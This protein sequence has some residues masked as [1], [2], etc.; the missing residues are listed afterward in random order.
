M[1]ANILTIIS[2]AL[3]GA[4]AQVPDGRWDG[5]ATY[6]TL[7]VPF[8][9][10]FE[11]KGKALTGSFMNG[12]SRTSSTEGSFEGNAVRLTFGTSG[13]RMEGT[14]KDGQLKGTI[15]TNGQD[16]HPFTASQF[17]SCAYEGEAGP[18]ISGAWKVPELN[19]GLNIRRK[20]EDTLVTIST[21]T[22]EFGPLTGRFD[23]AIFTL[24]YFDGARAA[25]LEIEEKK[26]GGLDLKLVESGKDVK[27]YRASK[28]IAPK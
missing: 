13:V 27:R 26:G 15:G 12:D 28:A 8:T 2:L 20:G 21:E 14:L 1:I 16:M 3:A 25:L 11:S 7:S 19:Q 24:H 23:G 9:I 4:W 10:N 6:G 5:T 22:G 18:D 17:C